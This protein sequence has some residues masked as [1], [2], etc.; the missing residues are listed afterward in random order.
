MG[1]R[2]VAAQLLYRLPKDYCGATVITTAPKIPPTTHAGERRAETKATNKQKKIVCTAFVKMMMDLVPQ[3]GRLLFH[4][5]GGGGGRG[6]G[7]DRGLPG[8]G[9]LGVS[10]SGE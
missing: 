1:R 9:R 7:P 6:N 4:Y 2:P 5:G 10:V 8:A 3:D